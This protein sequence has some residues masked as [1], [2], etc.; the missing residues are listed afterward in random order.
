MRG[1]RRH[2]AFAVA[3]AQL[4]A[5]G[6][7]QPTDHQADRAEIAK[8]GTIWQEAWNR[9][10]AAGLAS[11]MDEKVNFVS[12]LGPDT[13]GFGLPG[14]RN[15]FQAGHAALLKNMFDKSAWTTKSV[16]VVRFLR[17]D[18]AIAP[19][20]WETTGDKVRHV[21]HGTPRRGSFLWVVEKQPVGWRVVASQNTEVMPPLPGQ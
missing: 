7:A 17:P 21:A 6:L 4:P 18:V 5:L 13:P 9:R 15:A 2:F 14:D 10:D 3:I 16:A 20:L 1:L 8:L 19:V 12:V 11:I